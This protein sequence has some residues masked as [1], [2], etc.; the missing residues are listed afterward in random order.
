MNFIREC[1]L[2][3]KL[4]LYQQ[5]LQKIADGTCCPV[6]VSTAAIISG[7]SFNPTLACLSCGFP[8]KYRQLLSCSRC[9]CSGLC[10]DCL[11]DRL[12]CSYCRGDW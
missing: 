11:D 3:S 12:R 2:E 6:T 9:R 10:F 5:A 8:T 1:F 4:A 7:A